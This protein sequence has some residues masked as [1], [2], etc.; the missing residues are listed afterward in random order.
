V[1]APSVISSD[2]LKID[3]G[4][5]IDRIAAAIPASAPACARPSHLQARLMELLDHLVQ[6]A[7]RRAAHHAHTSA[8]HTAPAV[9]PTPVISK[10]IVYRRTAVTVGELYFDPAPKELGGIDLLRVL[11]VLCP[12]GKM[13]WK[14]SQTLVLDLTNT[15]DQL[16]DQMHKS[17]KY[18]VRRAQFR[19]N[20]CCKIY[21]LPSSEIAVQ[22]YKYYD[23]FAESKSLRPVFR[24]RLEALRR[25]RMLVLSSCSLWDSSD[26]ALVWHAYIR[27]DDRSML[28]Y[29]ASI[30]RE[31]SDTSFRSLVSRGNRY[32][33]WHDILYFK[34]QGLGLYDF[35]GMDVDGKSS[36][37]K[38]I[39]EFKRGFGGRIL[40][41]YSYTV[42]RSAKGQ[43]T[44]FILNRWGID[45]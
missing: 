42:P 24:A 4:A 12:K 17:T 19:D 8:P 32:L 20:V 31:S 9:V 43:L 18:K 28:L 34:S 15:A 25:Q 40:P 29:S 35:G 3:S 6:I 7:R 45:F 16:F 26:T 44:T 10:M 36:E 39:T 11:C 41:T 2:A 5:E 27:S 1:N 33:H 21:D 30:Y 23:R 22:F 38:R 14:Q 13:P 37:K